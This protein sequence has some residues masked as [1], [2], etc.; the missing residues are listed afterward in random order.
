ME[1][2][3]TRRDIQYTDVLLPQ[4]GV[5]VTGTAITKQGQLYGTMDYVTAK[6]DKDKYVQFKLYQENS[7]DPAYNNTLGEFSEPLVDIKRLSMGVEITAI[8]K[9]FKE[10]VVA[11][12]AKTEVAESTEAE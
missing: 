5:K 4:T 7:P 3:E 11:D 9:E 12:I 1:G 2:I 10:F 8:I 6:F